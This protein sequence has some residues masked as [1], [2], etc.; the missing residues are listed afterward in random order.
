[1]INLAVL[2]T[3]HNRRA[4]TIKCLKALFNQ[5]DNNNIRIKVFLVDDGSTDKTSKEVTNLFPEVVIIQG[6]PD[7]RK[8]GQGFDQRPPAKAACVVQPLKHCLMLFPIVLGIGELL[9][10]RS[11]Q[12][13]RKS[14]ISY[15]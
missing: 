8:K 1:M 14:F 3:C 5:V 7:L 15:K 10:D 2:I 9:I 4:K 11:F 6:H 12:K 13:S